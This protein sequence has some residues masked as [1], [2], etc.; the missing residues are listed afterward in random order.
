RMIADLLDLSRIE[1]GTIRLAH[2]SVSLAE[3]LDDVTQELQLFTQTKDQHLTVETTVDNLTVWGDP[4]RLHQILTNLVHN[5]HKFTPEH[6]HIRVKACPAPPDYIL[7]KISDTGPG[8]PRE[9]Q[10][11][12][13]QPFFQAHR[14]PEIG[15]QGLGLG[16][17][18]VKQLVELHGGTITVES[19]PGEGAT[20]CLRLPAV[21][22]SNPSPSLQ[23]SHEPPV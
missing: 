1:A 18:I 13:F 2:K 14:V 12:L 20:F 6:G 17:S 22:P 21:C 3:L 11:S 10:A 23:S 8:I 7:L 15:T 19:Q 16:L 4:D 9:A 5:A